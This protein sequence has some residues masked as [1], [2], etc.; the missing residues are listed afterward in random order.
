M[1]EVADARPVRGVD[2]DRQAGELVAEG[3]D[4]ADVDG[5]PRERVKSAGVAEVVSEDVTSASS[6]L[7]SARTHEHATPFS[8]KPLGAA[9]CPLAW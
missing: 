1:Y 5:V 8:V 7:M 4:R 3:G 2:R 9:A 6:S